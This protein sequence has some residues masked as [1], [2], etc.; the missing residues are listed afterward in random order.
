MSAGEALA[1]RELAS[2][3]LRA[4]KALRDE[5][6]D[7]HQTAFT[8]DAASEASRSARSYESR[9]GGSPGGT[10]TLAAWRGTRLVGALTIERDPRSKVHHVG[11]LVGMMVHDDVQREGVGRALL[12]AA[13]ARAA[14]DDGLDQLT[15]SVTSDNQAA[16]RLYE[17]FGFVRYGTH[18]RAVHVAGRFHDKDLMVLPLR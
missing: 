3:D 6:L 15:L 16:V 8:S 9:L 13:L 1:I 5:M 11:H 17:R 18:P 10:F 14:E 12:E 7:R 4:Y 2:A